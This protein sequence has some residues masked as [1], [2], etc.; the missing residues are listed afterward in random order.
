MV[1]SVTRNQD[2][3]VERA[4]RAAWLYYERELTQEEIARRLVVSRST[5]SRL[6]AYAR[7][8]GIVEISLTR[9]LPEVAALE[10]GLL[11]GFPL[12]TVIVEARDPGE[13]PSLVAARAGARFLSQ[14]ARNPA[15]IGVGWGSTLRAAAEAVPQLGAPWISL[16]DVVGRPPGDRFVA[17]SRVL[18]RAWSV[19]ALPI[20]AP[21]FPESTGMRRA[22][23]SDPVVRGALAR[24][25]DADVIVLSV[26]GTDP[27]ATLVEQGILT[28]GAMRR[29]RAAGAV[30]DLLGHFYDASGR[31]VETPGV[32]APVGLGLEELRTHRAVIAIAAGAAKVGGIRAAAQHG[33]I[34]GLVTDES[35]A[36][37]LLEDT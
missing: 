8:A 4:T 11:E 33:L 3:L 37:V 2:H 7:R 34:R 27:K 28:R 10:S 22:L 24:A 35:T 18:A 6:L 17:V 23:I 36:R 31:E 12:D 20:P 29:L 32:V 9:P 26:G 14:R 21:A 30:G 16:V 15:M 13:D 5:V 19:E 25:R 1:L